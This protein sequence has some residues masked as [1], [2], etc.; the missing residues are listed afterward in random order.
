MK[1]IAMPWS[2]VVFIQIVCSY[3]TNHE[4]SGQNDF[5]HFL[6]LL[7]RVR[8]A[9]ESFKTVETSLVE[10]MK[11]TT[12]METVAETM[13]ETL[14]ETTSKETNFSKSNES[15]FTYHRFATTF[16]ANKDGPGVFEDLRCVFGG[17]H[18]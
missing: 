12:S 16:G 10:T 6:T 13:N 1:K 2:L 9:Q 8:S 18:G 17:S 11:I 3:E 5:N 7:E 4:T 15:D 14:N